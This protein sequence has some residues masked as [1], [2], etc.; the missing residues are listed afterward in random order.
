MV[1][2]STKVKFFIVGSRRAEPC[3]FKAQLGGGGA[4]RWCWEAE[5]EAG[6]GSAFVRFS[7]K[8]NG[9]GAAAGPSCPGKPPQLPQS[10]TFCSPTRRRDVDADAESKVPFL[11]LGALFRLLND[12]ISQ[13]DHL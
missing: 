1:G 11:L 9:R 6:G 2:G 5:A 8:V 4:R 3:L 12:V 13:Q 7:C 10:P